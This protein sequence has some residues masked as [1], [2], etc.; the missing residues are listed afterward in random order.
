VKTILYGH[1]WMSGAL[2]AFG[3]YGLARAFNFTWQVWAWQVWASVVAIGLLWTVLGFFYVARRDWEGGDEDDTEDP[4][5]RPGG[6]RPADKVA[7]PSRR[8]GTPARYAAP[9]LMLLVFLAVAVLL[10]VA[11]RDRWFPTTRPA[12][13]PFVNPTAP[14]RR[15][16]AARN[17][18]EVREAA[19]RDRLKKDLW[20]VEDLYWRAEMRAA[21]EAKRRG[22]NQAAAMQREY[23]RTWRE[24]RRDL[25]AV[26]ARHGAPPPAELPGP[27]GL[28]IRPAGGD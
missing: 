12:P 6:G 27:P 16:A 2:T 7:G 11:A 24:R 15:A 4:A 1:A 5:P 26:Y 18:R 17:A 13:P 10:A 20:A 19:A 22:E 28:P 3:F 8:R 21:D 23:A 25:L 14:A 9:L